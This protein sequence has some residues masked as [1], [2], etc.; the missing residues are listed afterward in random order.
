MEEEVLATLLTEV[1]SILNSRPLC[2]V[3][4]DINDYES[5]TPNHLLLQ[6]AVQTLPPG[7]FVKEDIYARKKWRQTQILANHF[8][9]R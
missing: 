9:K 4:D 1:E 2:P 5:L 7:C 6:R 3:S 8:W